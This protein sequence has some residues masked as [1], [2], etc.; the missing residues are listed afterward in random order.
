MNLLR[1]QMLW[2]LGLLGPLAAV[3]LLKV[4]PV[5]RGTTALFLW[6]QI[7]R[8]KRSS[9]L[10]RRLRDILSLLLMALA[11]S[12]VVTAMGRP[13]LTS[14]E[15]ERDIVLLIDNSASMGATDGS[16]TRL[17]RAKQTAGDILTAMNLNRR[18]MLGTVADE[19]RVLVSLTSNQKSLMEGLREVS[20]TDLPFRRESLSA[21]RTTGMPSGDYRTILISD[22]CF[23]GGEG[24]DGV[25]L[26]KV[27]AS[28]ENVGIAALDASARFG[29]DERLDIY[30]QLAS[31]FKEDRALK[32]LI[33]RDRPE[34]VVKVYPVTVSPGLNPPEVLTVEPGG[35]GRWI[36][37]LD[38][39][40][41]LS[42][43]DTGYAAVP[44]PRPI[45]AAVNAE[46]GSFF[47]TRCVEAFSTRAN[48]M[49]L[50]QESP[51]VIIT[52]G[53]NIGS[54]TSCPRIIFNPTGSSPFWEELGA[55]CEPS[56]VQVL[57]PDHPAIQFSDVEACAFDGHVLITPPQGA[58][59]LAQTAD[60][61]PL[62]FK[63]VRDAGSAYVINMDPD[64]SEFFLS[65]Y[66]PVMVYSMAKALTGKQSEQPA[67][68]RVGS[69]VNV[70][71]PAKGQ[72]IS[73]TN[74]GGERAEL[75][76]G[77]IG[78]LREL[79][80][81]EV[82]TTRGTETLACSLLTPSESLL[83]NSE[84]ADTTGPLP[85]GRSP[86]YFLIAAAILIAAVESML[87]HRRRV[88]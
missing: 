67:C 59:V 64:R 19:V 58:V 7:L 62:I 72:V 36:L 3:Y 75:G 80:F 30:F 88:G 69:Y 51:E 82:K 22:G 11:A 21:F 1:P 14:T 77:R 54:Q 38:Q 63:S 28:A 46:K 17:A 86:S 29:S 32:V 49:T 42:K 33:S 25:E 16:R 35:Y 70:P 18:A 37:K 65:A 12:A 13:V 26:L 87:Y 43:D 68:I 45:R 60:G 85:R 73:V 71:P 47:F 5:R 44:E 6:D 31:S 27:G 66:F 40:D 79:G 4:R 24:L 57:I 39:T 56:P 9:A 76:T 78:P 48:L 10:L 20:Q 84:V 53:R 50:T 34:N 74:P 41:A 61:V 23:E 81:Y 2:F 83:D 8:E 55:P 15:D 52:S